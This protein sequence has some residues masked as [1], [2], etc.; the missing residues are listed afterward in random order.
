MPNIPAG[1]LNE[2]LSG[3][4][5]EQDDHIKQINELE[6]KHKYVQTEFT[7]N[8]ENAELD[9]H[10]AVERFLPRKLRNVSRGK[11][12]FVLAWKIFGII[13]REKAVESLWKTLARVLIVLD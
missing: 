5:K 12:C 2:C 8:L 1:K 11:R 6:D 9:Q 7:Q 10:K 3:Q 4:K 13:S